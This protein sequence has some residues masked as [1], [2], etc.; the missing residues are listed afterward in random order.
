MPKLSCLAAGF[1]RFPEI[2]FLSY[3]VFVIAGWEKYCL[4]QHWT[5]GVKADLIL[6]F[7]GIWMLKQHKVGNRGNIKEARP[8][9]PDNQQALPVPGRWADP[10][11][12]AQMEAAIRMRE[13]DKL[14]L[15]TA[16]DVP[17]R[18]K[19]WIYP[20]WVE[21]GELT[22]MAGPVDGGKTV[23][24]CTIAAGVTIGTKYSLHPELTPKG[25]GHVIFINRE[26]D[27]E[28]TLKPCLEA[29]GADLDKVHFIGSKTMPGDDSPFSFSNQRDLDRLMG[30]AERLRNE[31]GLLI[32]D[33][34]SFAVNGDPS[35]N[36]KAQQAYE[37]L[38]AL[39]KRLTCAILGIAQAVENP[40]DR[41]VLRRISGPPALRRVPRAAML[42]AKI[43]GGP[44][45][46]GGTH[47]FV[48][49]KNKDR[50]DGGFEYRITSV[51]IAGHDG[52]ITAP[53]LVITRELVGSPDDILDWADRGI[54]VGKVKKSDSAANLLLAALK[55]GPR[56]RND[57]EKLA[58]EADVKI[59]TLIA[60]KTLLK[61][62]TEKRKGD[63]R[64]VWRLLDSQ[65]ADDVMEHDEID[66]RA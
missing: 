37:A 51:K 5:V 45:E 43:S 54:T 26:D 14:D 35:N 1:R 47:V 15:T 3:L 28:T 18:S 24:Q 53:K 4:I 41:K 11:Y 59:G 12:C 10:H 33:P 44:T 55:D 19:I 40:L 62:K 61:I 2:F 42:L 58:R 65:D 63:G 17:S 49:A 30:L 20:D 23:L 6:H 13:T 38:T 21:Q 60:A 8:S 16:S 56:T 25:A 31:V 57:I 46:T 64:S 36:Y 22:V 39:S 66:Q 48:H 29:A 52:T 32:I 7:W 50:M 27:V 34:I 9:L